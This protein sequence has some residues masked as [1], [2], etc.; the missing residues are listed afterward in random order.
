MAWTRFP[1]QLSEDLTVLPP[2]LRDPSLQPYETKLLVFLKL[3][4]VAEDNLELLFLFLLKCWGYRHA[5]L[6]SAKTKSRVL[7]M[8]HEHT[9]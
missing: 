9:N 1:S 8:L 5:V 2:P 4:H 6:F 3:T 7:Y